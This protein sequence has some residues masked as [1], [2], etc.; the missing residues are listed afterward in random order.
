MR[1]LHRL[2]STVQAARLPGLHSGSAAFSSVQQQRGRLRFCQLAAGGRLRQAA[3]LTGPISKTLLQRTSLQ[4]QLSTSTGAE[5]GAANAK[6][7]AGAGAGIGAGAGAGAGATA[8]KAKGKWSTGKVVA[9][10][11]AATGVGTAVF[12]AVDDGFLRTLQFW[13]VVPKP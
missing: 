7:G 8:A 1:L 9:L 11:L 4:R 13:N 3:R 2:N 12:A 6:A 5:A 10:L